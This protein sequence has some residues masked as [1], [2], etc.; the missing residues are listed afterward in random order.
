MIISSGKIWHIIMYNPYTVAEPKKLD[1]N[2]VILAN[3]DQFGSIFP[4]FFTKTDI[5]PV[6]VNAD[7]HMTHHFYQ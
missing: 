7:E 1:K 3:L 4:I 5:I 2:I 6:S